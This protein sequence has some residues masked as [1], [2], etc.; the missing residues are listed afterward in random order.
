MNVFAAIAELST[1]PSSVT[2]DT[3]DNP[4]WSL[5]VS[6]LDEARA[7]SVRRLGTLGGSKAWCGDDRSEVVTFWSPA[8]LPSALCELVRVLGGGRRTADPLAARLA[9]WYG[10]HCD[11]D[12]EH[13]FG[14]CASL[15]S[16]CWAIEL[17]SDD[18]LAPAD[19]AAIQ[20][21]GVA[22]EVNDWQWGY[23]W[24]ARLSI[25]GRS[26]DDLAGTLDI[27]EAALA[28]GRRT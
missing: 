23:E 20:R 28:A 26:W 14:I 1:P 2:F 19:V 3:L 7:Q 18:D 8:D 6:G 10:A 5:A 15:T 24:F 16:G 9:D 27:L 11:G 25:P 22:V 12:W 21:L 17:H 13:T 4:G